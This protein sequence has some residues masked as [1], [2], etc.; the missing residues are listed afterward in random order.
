MNEKQ[1]RTL[2]SASFFFKLRPARLPESG[3]PLLK[4]IPKVGDVAW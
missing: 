3:S 4:P 2:Y 1:L